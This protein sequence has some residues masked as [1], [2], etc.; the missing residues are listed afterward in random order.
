MTLPLSDNLVVCEKERNDDWVKSVLRRLKSC[1]DLVA[2]EA[3]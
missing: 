2:E 1:N 3:V